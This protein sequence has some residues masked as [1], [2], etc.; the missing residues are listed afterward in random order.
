MPARG[1]RQRHPRESRLYQILEEHLD[2]FEAAYEEQF[3]GRYGRLRPSPSRGDGEECVMPAFRHFLDCTI[4]SKDQVTGEAVERL[5]AMELLARLSLHVP[6]AYQPLRFYYGAFSNH[7]RHRRAA[8]QTPQPQ[9]HSEQQ[10]QPPDGYR[11]AWRRRWAHLITK[12]YGENPLVCPHCGGEM[13]VL[14]LIT[15]PKTI[16][17]ILGFLHGDGAPDE[18]RQG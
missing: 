9:P 12:I 6:Q 18:V 14:G 2:S 10:E 13:K 17:T 7:A 1:Y 4:R 15:E 11:K 5:S 3:A 8:L 16:D